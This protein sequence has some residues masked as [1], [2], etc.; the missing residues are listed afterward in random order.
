MLASAAVLAVVSFR[1]RI[2][3]RVATSELVLVLDLVLGPGL[4]LGLAQAPET[5]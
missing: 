4:E 1:P 3:G 5:G 2:H